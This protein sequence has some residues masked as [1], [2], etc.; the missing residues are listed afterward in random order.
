M[1]ARPRVPPTDHRYK[2]QSARKKFNAALD[3]LILWRQN[4]NII[5]ISSLEPDQDFTPIGTLNNSGKQQFW[6]EFDHH[7]KCLDR[8]KPDSNMR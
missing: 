2:V 7:F 6:K 8:K 4:I 1:I 3:S 5:D